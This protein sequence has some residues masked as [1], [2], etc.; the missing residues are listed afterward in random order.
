MAF[1]DATGVAAGGDKIQATMVFER[2]DWFRWNK[3]AFRKFSQ[4]LKGFDWPSTYSAFGA[5]FLTKFFRSTYFSTI[6]FPDFVE[7]SLLITPRAL[8]FL[9]W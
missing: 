3:S 7:P 4:K 1:D 5:F 2:I 6:H 9:M 8:N